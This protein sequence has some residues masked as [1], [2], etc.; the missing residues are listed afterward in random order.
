MSDKIFE[1]DDSRGFTISAKSPEDTLKFCVFGV[2]D[3]SEVKRI[4]LLESP[5][6]YA[7]L[8][9][10]TITGTP[11]S[12][13]VWNIEAKYGVNAPLTPGTG[14]GGGS[15]G[16]GSGG[17]GG[18]GSDPGG[19]GSPPTG[20]A[21]GTTDVEIS[22]TIGETNQHI[23]QSKG[24]AGSYAPTGHT[25]PDYKG[26]IGVTD[27]SVEGA[28]VGITTV[29]RSEKWPVPIDRM[30]LGYERMLTRRRGHTN[31]ATFRG[32]AAG[33][34]CFKNFETS[35]KST[36][37]TV[38]V[39]FHFEISYNIED[40][41]IGDIKGIKKGGWQYLWVRYKD[42]KDAAAKVLVKQPMAVYVEDMPGYEPA[43]FSS[44]GIGE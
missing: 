22:F 11:V 8:R 32:Y 4:A 39:T 5:P 16:G 15:G 1:T 23:T 10:Q 31:N 27:D 21:P 13:Y 44:F 37:V 35:Y 25:A 33:E 24:T 18:G 17:V 34:V 20:P 30:T 14:S 41:A 26:A 29:T 6:T 19:S 36:D 42:V 9:L 43:D 7:G 28:D 2:S 38:E 40:L 12:T 3:P